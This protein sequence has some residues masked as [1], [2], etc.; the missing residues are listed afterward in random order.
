MEEKVQELVGVIQKGADHQ[1]A[2]KIAV[3]ELGEI[4]GSQELVDA[5]QKMKDISSGEAGFIEKHRVF[6][7]EDQEPEV[8]ELLNKT[9]TDA[10]YPPAATVEDAVEHAAGNMTPQQT[11][12][13]YGDKAA[14]Y[15]LKKMDR[16][17][18]VNDLKGYL[19]VLRW[20]QTDSAL[21]LLMGYKDHPD[22]G[23]R[24]KAFEAFAGHAAPKVLKVLK[25][26][27]DTETHYMILPATGY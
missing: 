6:V 22:Q 17:G 25:S 3:V 10:G 12:E 16:G 11:G 5:V 21:D 2:R 19:P 7:K 18:T 15:I 20:V 4:L 14:S 13:W 1:A 23:V 24:I 8:W 9:L 26:H 27:L